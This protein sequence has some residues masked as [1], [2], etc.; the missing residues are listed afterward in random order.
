[1]HRTS[2]PDSFWSPISL[3]RRMHLGEP[4]GHSTLPDP[5]IYIYICSLSDGP[6]RKALPKA[7]SCKFRQTRARKPVLL[8]SPP[9]FFL[10]Q[11]WE[12]AGNL[13]PFRGPFAKGSGILCL[14]SDALL[15]PEAP[16]GYDFGFALE[17]RS[18]GDQRRTPATHKHG[19]AF[20]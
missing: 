12:T 4:Q 10:F 14:P 20:A 13:S 9:P 8:P 11:P 18:M 5:V 2:K 6:F 17:C 7:F 19:S 15:W 16:R 3:E 1:M